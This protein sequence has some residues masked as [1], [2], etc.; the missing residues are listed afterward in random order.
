MRRHCAAGGY[1]GHIDLSNRAVSAEECTL[2]ENYKI[3]SRL[4]SCTPLVI[5]SLHCG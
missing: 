1:S 5:A 2:S 4:Q 3:A